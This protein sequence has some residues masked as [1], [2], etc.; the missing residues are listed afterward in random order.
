MSTNLDNLKRLYYN[1][2]RIR[3]IEEKIADLYSEQEMRCPVHL[4]IGQEA[5]AVGVCS[6]LSVQ[7][8][9]LSNHRSHAHYL[10]KG[11]DL[12]AMLAEIYGKAT[13]CSNGKGGS[14]HLV[15]LSV[16][17]LGSAPIVGSTIPI[18]VGAAF[19]GVMKGQSQVVVSFFGDGATEEGVF[20]ESLNFALLKKLPVIFVCENNYYSVYSPL[21]VRQPESR[22]IVDIVKGVG[23][24]SFE[25][26]GNDALQVY[27]ITE[28][29]VNEIRDGNGPVFLKFDTYRWR[30]H[31]GPN[32]DNDLG[33]RTESEFQEWKK[34]DP[35]KLLAER[36]LQD[37]AIL[38]QDLD[39]IKEII[40]NE[41]EEA[42]VFAKQ[43]PFP[44]ESMLLEDIYA[45]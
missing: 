32:Y 14:M 22:N 9:V 40:I 21:S 8:Y 27:E 41:I 26:D 37:K 11:G 42:V 18:A 20:Y 7:D 35:V 13:G 5:I 23:I 29:A 39:S 31:C 17:F 28:R 10:A 44:E 2:L 43:S 24:K 1:T 12:K 36:L 4:S 15:D 34:R 19:G 45:S 6:A 16:G 38:Q 30:E 3:L 25:G 33:Y